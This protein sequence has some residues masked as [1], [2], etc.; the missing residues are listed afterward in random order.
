MKNRIF[1]VKIEIIFYN[2]EGYPDLWT[3]L[4][5]LINQINW[6]TFN[7]KGQHC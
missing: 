6:F 1:E 3:A 2:K 4:L 7:T 5:T